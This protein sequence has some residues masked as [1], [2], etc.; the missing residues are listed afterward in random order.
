MEYQAHTNQVVQNTVRHGS[1]KSIFDI[2]ALPQH[3]KRAYLEAAQHDLLLHIIHA[4]ILGAPSRQQESPISTEGQG[5]EAL[6]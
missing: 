4:Y 3:A 5:G 6:P 1:C 2:G